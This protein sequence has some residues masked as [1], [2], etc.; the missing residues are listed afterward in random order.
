VQHIDLK[1]WSRRQQFAFFRDFEDPFFNVTANVD[2]TALR[3]VSDGDADVSF[4][5]GYFHAALTAANTVENFRYRMRG[6]GVVLYELI[7][8]GSTV[9][10]PDETFGFGYFRFE[11]DFAPFQRGLREGLEKVLEEGDSFDPKDDRD[12]LI[13]FT[14][15]PWVAFTGTKHARR[16]IPND[17]VPKIA[18]GK[19]HEQNGRQLLPI[20]V[21][22]NHALVDGLHIGRFFEALQ[23]YLDEFSRNV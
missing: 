17:S 3:S 11:R 23:T 14:V 20:S 4:S 7:H 2:V 22:V 10:K 18:I 6:D 16:P 21:D 9:L 12:D 19:C 1:S 13:H 15:I 8:G 5:A